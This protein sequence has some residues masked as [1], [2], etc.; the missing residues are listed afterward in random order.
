MSYPKFTDTLKEIV[1]VSELIEVIAWGKTVPHYRSFGYEC[2][3]GTILMVHYTELTPSSHETVLVECPACEERRTVQY[4]NLIKT[5]HSLCNG[6]AKA[7]DLTGIKFGK[8]TA[9]YQISGDR[10]RWYC[11]CECGGNSEAYVSTL[12]SGNSQSCG[13]LQKKAARKQGLSN[14]GKNN[15][16]YGKRAWNYDPERSDEQRKKERKDSKNERWR[17]AVFLRD[18][19]QC[20]ACGDKKGGNLEA[21]H[22]YNWKHHPNKRYDT[23]NGISLCKTCHKEFHAWMGGTHVKCTE[24]DYYEWLNI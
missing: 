20:Q 11:E 2:T 24:G 10:P 6:C 18:N 4:S 16:M 23:E 15:G 7:Y 12:V 14:N 5:G 8:M 3:N 19:H 9:I 17:V 1:V 21:H 22:L 13:C